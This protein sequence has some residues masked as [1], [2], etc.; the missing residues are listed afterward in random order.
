MALGLGIS[1]KELLTEY[2]WDEIIVI[3]DEYS[4]LHAIEENE[5]DIPITSAE[6][7]MEFMKYD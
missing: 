4:I 6:E 7:E 3:F 2:Y 5:E 1:K